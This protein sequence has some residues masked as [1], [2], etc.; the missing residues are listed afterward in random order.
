MLFINE[1]KIQ[2]LVNLNFSSNL[3]ALEQMSVGNYSSEMVV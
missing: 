1:K 2:F 3:L